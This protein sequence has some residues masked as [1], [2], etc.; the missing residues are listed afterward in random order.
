MLQSKNT[1]YASLNLQERL[2][3]LYSEYKPEEVLVTSSFGVSSAYLLGVIS[4]VN[5]LQQIHFIDTTFSFPETLSYKK[6]LSTKLGLKVVDVKPEKWEN[7]FTLKD[8]TW[9]KD[10]NM[11]CSVNKVRPLE[12]LKSGFKIWISGLMSHQNEARAGKD[13]FELQGDLMK[14]YPLLD[15]TNIDMQ[16]FISENELPEHPLQLCGYNSIGCF[17]CTM[18]GEGREGR[19]TGSSKTECGLHLS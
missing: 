4:K 11:C 8:E 9:T 5:P 14:F 19:W 16:E 18:K 7:D 12:K 17:H 10:P 3:A 13:F 6:K 15:R 2:R 1:F